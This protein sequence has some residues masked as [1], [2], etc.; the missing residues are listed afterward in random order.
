LIL[1]HFFFKYITVIKLFT[2]GPPWLPF[3]GNILLV[4]RLANIHKFHHLM[5]QKLANIYGPVM[6]LRLG[7]DKV[8]VVSGKEAIKEFYA[9]DEFDGRPDGFFFR[10]RSFDKRLGLVFVDGSFWE[11]QRKFTVKTLKQ[12]G[13]GR[14]GMVEN[15]ERE[16]LALVD[17]VR[18]R[19]LANQPIQAHNLFDVSVLNVM[20]TFVAGKRLV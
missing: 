4:K 9:K 13:M 8:I 3:L 18:A 20:W 14:L 19:I 12:L 5:W 17:F 1:E 10:V 6:G 7:N 15:V 2:L 16:A 11:T